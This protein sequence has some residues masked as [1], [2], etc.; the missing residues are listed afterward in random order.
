MDADNDT[1][2]QMRDEARM[3]SHPN[4]QHDYSAIVEQHVVWGAA[5]AN[6]LQVMLNRSA[7]VWQP[8][9][10]QSARTHCRLCWPWLSPLGTKGWWDRLP[11]LSLTSNI[12][13]T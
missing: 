6:K 4:E 13:P 1:L 12:T 7:C 3:Q 10:E 2:E 9:S 11:L 5:S 8:E